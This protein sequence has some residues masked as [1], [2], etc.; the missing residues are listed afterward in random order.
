MIIN[1][2]FSFIALVQLLVI[3]FWVVVFGDTY[4]GEELINCH[5]DDDVRVEPDL[6][7][8]EAEQFVDH[9]AVD[10]LVDVVY[11]FRVDQ[12]SVVHVVLAE[13]EYYG[14]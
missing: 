1:S 12:A 2:V 13:V 5:G 4:G 8:D 6:R 7:V 14:V 10:E 9:L 3:F 11:L